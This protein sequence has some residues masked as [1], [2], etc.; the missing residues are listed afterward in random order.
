LQSI[1]KF[2]NKKSLVVCLS[3]GIESKTLKTMDGLMEEILPA[4]QPYCVLSGPMLAE[5]LEKN[6]K[7]FAV[8]AVK[9]KKDFIRLN[10]IFNSTN[11][12]IGYSD[13]LRGV[14]LCGV[15]KNIY[16]L[17]LGIIDGLELGNNVKGEFSA[18]AVVE[19]IKILKI[20]GGKEE[21]VLTSAGIADLITTAFSPYSRNRKTGENLGKEGTCC[22]DSEGFRSIR[23]IIKMLGKNTAKCRFLNV[24]KL[25]ILGNKRPKEAFESIL[26]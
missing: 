24:L 19:M 22:L 18:Y 10:E 9:N 5:E 8:A 15:L 11:L 1:V 13:D 17:G 2:L 7:G 21:G 16:S 12:F 6:K 26:H 25:I 4:N 20:L 3:K 23:S 14:A